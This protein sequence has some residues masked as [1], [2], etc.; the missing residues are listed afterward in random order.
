MLILDVRYLVQSVCSYSRPYNAVQLSIGNLKV[1]AGSLS[2]NQCCDLQAIWTV[3]LIIDITDEFQQDHVTAVQCTH[4]T[5][6][7][8]RAAYYSDQILS[9]IQ[10][11]YQQTSI[12]CNGAV[13]QQVYPVFQAVAYQVVHVDTYSLVIS[14]LF[15]STNG[16]GR[17][18]ALCV[19]QKQWT[20]LSWNV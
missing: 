3:V 6:H 1:K 2:M 13:A 18:K 14:S 5:S 11:L 12:T 9:A 17:Q 4:T 8:I 20:N 16:T 19:L 10:L 7:E 15:M